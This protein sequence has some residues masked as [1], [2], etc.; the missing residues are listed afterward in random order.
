MAPDGIML[1]LL[2]SDRWLY[3]SVSPKG[4]A[5]WKCGLTIPAERPVTSGR[6]IRRRHE[7][8]NHCPY[9][10]SFALGV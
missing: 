5:R 6:D 10:F 8:R 1:A 7:E 2:I 4:I 3:F 9:R